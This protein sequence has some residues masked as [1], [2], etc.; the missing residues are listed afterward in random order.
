MTAVNIAGL[1]H[2][3]HRKMQ[4][5]TYAAAKTRPSSLLPEPASK[6]KPIAV[7]VTATQHGTPPRHTRNVGMHRAMVSRDGRPCAL[8]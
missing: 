6:A 7:A 4:P 2:R 3:E 5:S 1:P 8:S